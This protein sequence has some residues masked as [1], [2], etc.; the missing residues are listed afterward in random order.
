MCH[1]AMLL[2]KFV[3][4]LHIIRQS[5][6]LMLTKLKKKKKKTEKTRESCVYPSS[7]LVKQLA[8]VK[9]FSQY[10]ANLSLHLNSFNFQIYH[11]LAIIS[12]WD[13]VKN[14]HFKEMII[15]RLRRTKE[16]CFESQIKVSPC[17]IWLVLAA[18]SL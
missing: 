10:C 6:L 2:S 17:N 15:W 13:T 14:L 9:K 3:S 18:W 1:W 11:S 7:F 8:I 5:P 4:N 16:E 12:P